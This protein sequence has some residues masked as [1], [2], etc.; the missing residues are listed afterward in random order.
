MSFYLED[1]MKIE[2]RENQLGYNRAKWHPTV[3]NS[4]FGRPD[5]LPL[6]VADM[7]FSVSEATIHALQSRLNYPTFGYEFRSETHFDSFINWH[8][9][10][11]DWIIDKEEIVGAR[12]LLNALAVIINGYTKTGDAVMINE[13][14]YRPFFEIPKKLKRTIINVPLA[15]EDDKYVMDFINIETAIVKNDVK[16]FIM[17]NPHNPTGR[18]WTRSELT[19][20]GEICLK[21]GVLIISDEIHSNFIYKGFKFVPFMSLNQFSEIAVTL[22]S[23]GKTFNIPSLANGLV[24]TRITEIRDMVAE[25]NETFHTDGV[26]TF[27]N[28]VFEEVYK[29][30]EEWFQ[31][32]MK[33]LEENRKFAIEYIRTNMPWIKVDYPEGTYLLWLDMRDRFEEQKELEDFLIQKAGLAL[34]SGLFF[35]SSCVGFARLN[36]ATSKQTLVEA[37]ERLAREY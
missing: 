18:V 24:I 26:N 13:P 20:L 10:K 21:H 22:T 36:Y 4:T 16:V 32:I 30:G 25:F 3:L 17:A 28:L 8:L 12:S 34:N 37:L 19:R 2:I 9:K 5:L 11:D 15:R 27:S 31:S 35:G 29:N 1:K 14:V 7:D 6:W 33:I 23:A